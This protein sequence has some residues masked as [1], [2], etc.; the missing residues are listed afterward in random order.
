M[1]FVASSVVMIDTENTF[2]PE[3][4]AQ[5]VK[6]LKGGED[7]DPEEF[8][9]N[10]V[11]HIPAMVFAKDAQQQAGDHCDQHTLH[12]LS[13]EWFHRFAPFLGSLDPFR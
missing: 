3:R 9:K 6:G 13:F 2:R 7:L 1:M 11:D 8:L 5:M 4:I 12:P 10:I